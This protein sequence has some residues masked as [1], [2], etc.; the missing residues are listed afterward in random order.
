MSV[1]TEVARSLPPTLVLVCDYVSYYAHRFPANEAAVCDGERL[2]FLEL[3][4][5]VALCAKSLIAAGICKGD[6]VATLCT[7]HTDFLT[8]FL[9]SGAIGA[10]WLGLNPKYQVD[11][12]KAVM[13]DAEPAILFSR[14]NIAGRDFGDDL[15]NLKSSMKN[16]LQVVLLGEGHELQGALSFSE[17]Q[18]AGSTISDESLRAARAGVETA[19]PTLIV[20]TSGSTGRP[21]GAVI[22]HYAL[23]KCC[24][25]TLGHWFATP[26]RILNFLPINHIGCVGDI[27][28]FCLIGGGTIIFMEQF[29]AHESLDL[30]EK[31]NITILGG[32]PTTLQMCATHPDFAKYDYSSVQLIFWS[33]A[34]ASPDLVRRLRTVSPRQ[35]MSYGMT[36]T[37]GSVTFS[38]VCD[39]VDILTNTIGTPAQE[40]EVKLQDSPKPNATLS[41]VGELLVRG[42]FMMTEYWRQPEATNEAIDSD[43]WLHTGD[44]AE[45]RADGNF[46]LI[47]RI[48]EMFKSGGYNIYPR[49]VES[50]IESHPNIS[51]AVVVPVPD[52]LYQEVGV[53]FVEPLPHEAIEPLSLQKY[54]KEKMANYKVPKLFVVQSRLPRLPVGKIDKKVLRESALKLKR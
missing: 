27:S 1:M 31:E 14:H 17:Y 6:R 37:V 25:T 33:G 7:P 47:G 54:C 36:E 45:I 35:S 53:A 30:I 8:L 39:D 20:Y 43:G 16:E 5:R 22:S 12:L 10:I 41:Q 9:A 24:R 44:L 11:E 40:Y 18:E 48:K 52:E 26:L 42:D 49:E 34:A 15:R 3:E 46:R 21:K 28:C 50:V 38:S 4:R 23:I 51:V 13:E 29:D 19:D 2:S 32:V